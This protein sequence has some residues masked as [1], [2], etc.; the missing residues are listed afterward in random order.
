MVVVDIFISS[1]GG[2]C[3]EGIRLVGWYVVNMPFK[4]IHGVVR[5]NEIYSSAGCQLDIGYKINANDRIY[6]TC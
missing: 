2:R 3:V 6:W 5:I 4:C 1:R